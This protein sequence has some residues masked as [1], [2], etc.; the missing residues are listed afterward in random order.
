MTHH[1]SR[2]VSY[3]LRVATLIV[4]LGMAAPPARAGDPSPTLL[5]VEEISPALGHVSPATLVD[6]EDVA[7]TPD[8]VCGVCSIVIKPTSSGSSDAATV[9]VPSDVDFRGDLE[10]MVWLDGG[11]RATGSIAGVAI[12]AGDLVAIE[13]E[14][15]PGWSW[16]QVRHVWTRTRPTS[17]DD[18]AAGP[19]ELVWAAAERGE[20]SA[21]ASGAADLDVDFGAGFD[22]TATL[23]V[24]GDPPVD[25]GAAARAAGVVAGLE[26]A[27]GERLAV[28]VEAGWSFDWRN[29]RAAWIELTPNAVRDGKLLTAVELLSEQNHVLPVELPATGE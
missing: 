4:A 22:G 19:G 20:A 12:A 10:V 5:T 17:R 25:A 15:G 2:A 6:P 26:E 7:E 28:R 18:A 14:P 27:A 9:I 8:P 24:I 21:A 13:A 29:V 1:V 16:R 11:V 3:R 23:V